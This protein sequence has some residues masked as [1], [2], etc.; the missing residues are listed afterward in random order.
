MYVGVESAG[1]P[2]IQGV[3]S[4]CFRRG[5]VAGPWTFGTYMANVEDAFRM[6]FGLLAKAGW[7]LAG[8]C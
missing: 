5:K 4:R 8:V 7:L 6:H 3:M 2:R 1:K